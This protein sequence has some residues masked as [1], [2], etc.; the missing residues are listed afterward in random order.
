L[1]G[2]DAFELPILPPN[3]LRHTLRLAK[4]SGPFPL[5]VGPASNP[6]FH[7]ELATGERMQTA[8]LVGAF[9]TAWLVFAAGLW[10]ARPRMAPGALAALSGL[11]L[12]LWG[13]L[14]ARCLLAWSEILRPLPQDVLPGLSLTESL[15]AL[16]ILPALVL[17]AGRL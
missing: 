12:S 16:A 11:A 3:T 15:A 5:S 14:I 17:L 10:I 2:D 7:V 6:A 1:P 13:L 9:A 4:G 8:P